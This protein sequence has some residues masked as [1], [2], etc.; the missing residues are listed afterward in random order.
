LLDKNPFSLP[1]G[2]RITCRC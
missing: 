2:M 1:K